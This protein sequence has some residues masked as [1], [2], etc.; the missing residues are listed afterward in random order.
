MHF[1]P[2]RLD[3]SI[4]GFRDEDW[5]AHFNQADYEGSWGGIALRARSG[6][7]HP[8]LQLTTHWGGGDW[9]ETAWLDR[10]AYLRDVLGAFECP[11]GSARMPSTIAERRRGCTSSSTAGAMT[12]STG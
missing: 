1:D 12:G 3:T 4:K 5:T 2:D 6:A 9:I 10:C 8:I 11:I 7:D